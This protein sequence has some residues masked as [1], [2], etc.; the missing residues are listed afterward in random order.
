MFPVRQKVKLT[1]IGMYP[2]VRAIPF[3]NHHDI[4]NPHTAS[5]WSLLFPSM[6]RKQQHVAFFLNDIPKR[7]LPIICNF[8][9]NI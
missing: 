5:H 7:I 6:C 8:Q 1:K 3:V 9:L 4:M 2:I